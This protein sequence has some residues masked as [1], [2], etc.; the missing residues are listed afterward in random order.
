[1]ILHAEELA[2]LDDRRDG[3]AFVF[4]GRAYDLG[5]SVAAVRMREIGP[6][7]RLQGAVRDGPQLLPAD[8]RNAPG[9]NARHAAGKQTEPGAHAVF[10]ALLEEELHAE[11]DAEHRRP[12]VQRLLQGR[13]EIQR[14]LNSEPERRH[15]RQHH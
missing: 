5:R 10:L 8:V 9:R 4:D 2:P 7:R 14:P 6:T 15:A 3:Y 12:A 11:T 1:M 13:L